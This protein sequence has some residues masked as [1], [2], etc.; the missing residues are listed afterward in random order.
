MEY[1]YHEVSTLQG[2]RYISAAILDNGECRISGPDSFDIR[3]ATKRQMAQ[4]KDGMPAR[5]MARIDYD[6]D[7]LNVKAILAGDFDA[8]DGLDW[9]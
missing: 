9:S 8:V 1:A 3:V 2:P 6:P 7:P 4:S 5:G